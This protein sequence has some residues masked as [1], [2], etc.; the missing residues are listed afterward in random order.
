MR[1][2]DVIGPDQN[3]MAFLNEARTGDRVSSL[4]TIAIITVSAII[5]PT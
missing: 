5:M 2:N 3:P 4:K 1:F